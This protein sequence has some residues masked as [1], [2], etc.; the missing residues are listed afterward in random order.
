M[1]FWQ[2]LSLN[3]SWYLA[4]TYN[5]TFDPLLP[6]SSSYTTIYLQT[7]NVRNT[8]VEASLGY[9]HDWNG[10]SWDSNFT[11]SWNRNEI[12]DLA[13]NAV[14]PVTGEP[15]DL[16]QLD[17]KALGKSKFILKKGALLAIYILHPISLPIR[18]DI[19]KLMIMVIFPLQMKRQRYFLERYSPN[20][21]WRG[22]M[23][24]HG[25]T[26]P[27][28]SRLRTYRRRMLFCNS[29]QS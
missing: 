25:R 16:D 23:T 29:S 4:D 12:L 2:D 8:G 13:S 26:S 1:T 28:I 19:L 15:L 17:I 3:L 14:N 9:G 6:P 24:S 22:E 27:W 5:Q 18:R 7:G 10:F 21:I 20:T 11:F